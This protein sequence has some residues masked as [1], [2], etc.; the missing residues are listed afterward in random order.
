MAFAFA[1]AVH[2]PIVV[3][4]DDLS[5]HP[6]LACYGPFII[7]PVIFFFFNSRLKKNLVIVANT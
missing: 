5:I 2:E 1:I 7:W 4:A 6:G 3:F